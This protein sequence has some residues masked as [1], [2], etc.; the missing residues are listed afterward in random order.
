MIFGTVA[1]EVSLFNLIAILNALCFSVMVLDSELHGS[2][3]SLKLLT[4]FMHAILGAL[5][6]LRHVTTSSVYLF[7]CLSVRP[8]E[9]T[10]LLEDGFSLI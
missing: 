10:R 5:S 8:R 3:H 6:K 1:N 2:R 9:T 7:I 4:F